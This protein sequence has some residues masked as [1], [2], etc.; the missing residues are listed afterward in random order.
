MQIGMVG[1]GRMGG[2]M[3][4]RL[5]KGGHQC[6]VFDLN[7]DNV[8]ELVSQ[9]AAGATSMEDFVRKLT[10]PRIAWVM[11]P[12]GDPTEKTI[13][14]LGKQMEEND[15]IVDGGRVDIASYARRFREL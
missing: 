6:V 5:I 2:N 3:V 9:G 1:L 8:A 7:Q 12:S 4:R 14:A 10:T 11:V 15:I 13:D